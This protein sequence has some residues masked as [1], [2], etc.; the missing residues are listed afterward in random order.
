MACISF[1]QASFKQGTAKPATRRAVRVMAVHQPNKPMTDFVAAAAAAV[2]LASSTA[3]A[4]A[5]PLNPAIP[6]LAGP[7]GK[8]LN[9][10]D[11]QDP[12]KGV[13]GPKV[14]GQFQAEPNSGLAGIDAKPEGLSWKNFPKPSK[15]TPA[16]QEK[17]MGRGF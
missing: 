5:S 6:E 12:P 3:P 15:N 16:N 11:A 9:K 17:A 4:L 8:L 7:V 1:R 2:L 10:L 14:E 13:P